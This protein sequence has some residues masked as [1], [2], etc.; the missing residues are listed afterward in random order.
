MSPSCSHQVRALAAEE[1]VIR[2]GIDVPFEAD[3]RVNEQK[4]QINAIARICR[5]RDA[6]FEPGQWYFAGQPTS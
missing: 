3:M 2:Y 6:S 4:R 5:S 1:L